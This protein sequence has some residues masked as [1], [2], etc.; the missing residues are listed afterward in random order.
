MAGVA[1]PSI[2]DLLA[3]RYSLAAHIN[4]DSSGRQVWRGMDVLLNRPVTV[5]LRTPGGPE[6]EE[7]LAAAV[8]ASRVNHPNIVGVY[9][10]VDQGDCAYVVREWVDGKSL[11]DAIGSSALAIDD[12][13]D[14]V[15][16][17]SDAVAAVHATG[18][19]H[20]NIHPGTIL[21]SSDDRAVLAD[22]RA[23][24]TATQ[25]GDVRALGATLY[26]ALSGGWPRTVPGPASLPDAPADA[27]GYPV[28]ISQLRDDVPERLATLITDLL[29]AQ[30]A[31]PTAAELSEELSRQ[32]RQR[33]DTGALALVT[34]DPENVKP[35]MPAK[36]VGRRLAIGAG[37]LVGLA[38]LGLLAAMILIPADTPADPGTAEQSQGTEEGGGDD[39][40]SA[41]SEPVRLDLTPD[42]ISVIDPGDGDT[43][44]KNN[45]GSV[46]DG[47]GNTQW[48]TSVYWQQ[49]WGGF[50]EGMGLLVDLGE[51]R[52]IATVN[53]RMPNPG[54]TVGL[55]VGD[56]SMAGTTPE[57]VVIAEAQADSPTSVT[58][59]P[60]TD[61][62]PTQYLLIWCSVPSEIGADEFQW[63][64]NELEIFAR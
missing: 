14:I 44:A 48:A 21:L 45:P 56:P 22:P 60:I 17:V 2:G 26:C 64:V 33:D 38:I 7:M 27:Q 19:A 24:A 35:P 62:P 5:V 36:A 6:A 30:T 10:A 46:V 47:D 51:V 42:A 20:G 59:T 16:C 3:D 29:S 28:P 53:L 57:L 31:P 9:D 23:D 25:V 34:P 8:A 61:A 15:Q 13:V 4:D 37:A 39:D 52:D 11:R 58:F 40:D 1:T 43:S 50:K 49:N 55:Y 63:V 18:V 41:P 12:I 54:A 32:T